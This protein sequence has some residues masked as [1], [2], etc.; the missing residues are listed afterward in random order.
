MKQTRVLLIDDERNL[1][2]AVQEILEENGME[3]SCGGSC[4]EAERLWRQS[5]PDLVVLDYVLPDGNAIDLINKFKGSDATVP[6]IVLT[7]H[8]TIDLAV[9]AVQAGADNFLTK[10]ADPST[11]LVMMERSLENSRNRQGRLVEESKTRR[12]ATNPFLGVSHAIA[13]LRDIA[14]KVAKADSPVLIQGETGAGK[15]VLA[16]WLHASSSHSSAPYVDLNC[17]GLPRDLLETELFGHE[18]GAFTGAVQAKVG[19]FEAAHKGTLFLDEI[20][21]IDPV[22]Q[23][24]LLKVLE[25]KRFRRLGDIRDRFAEVRL[26]AATHRDLPGLVRQGKFRDD[27]YFRI[28]TIPLCIPPLRERRE[29][30]PLLARNLLSKLSMDMGKAVEITDAAIQKLQAYSWPGNIRELRNVLERSI[31]LGSSAILDEPSVRFDP[32][33]IP[34]TFAPSSSVRTLEEIEKEHIQ[35]VLSLENG[36]VEST[37]KRLGIPRSSLYLKLKQYGIVKEQAATFS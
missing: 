18:K 15:G 23:P 25:E 10:P 35:T 32:L 37:A 8:G 11:L 21:D 31:L 5:R 27:L 22:V 1:L 14:E 7:G 24:K 13:E 34:G 12:E 6:I 29:D 3:V 9:K 4:A 17:A 28:S 26:I 2:R 20:G 16:R 30:I 36:R 19:L 33:N